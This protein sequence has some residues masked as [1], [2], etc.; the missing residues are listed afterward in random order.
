[1]AVE[2]DEG[3]EGRAVDDELGDLSHRRHGRGEHALVAVFEALEDH[4]RHLDEALLEACGGRAVRRDA[5]DGRGHPVQ[6]P[7]DLDEGG[8]VGACEAEELHG[9]A[10]GGLEDAHGLFVAVQGS[11][12][13]HALCDLVVL[14]L[15]VLL[16]H[17]RTEGLPIVPVDLAGEDGLGDA[18][19]EERAVLGVNSLGVVGGC[20][21]D[22]AL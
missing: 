2:F 15:A 7:P 12:G 1:M 9:R 10:H 20:I 6:R 19:S 3:V 21:D 4:G 17:E 8:V 16:G 11:G 5:F 14:H 22:E 13:F 18:F